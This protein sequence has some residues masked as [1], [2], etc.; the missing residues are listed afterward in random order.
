ML[1]PEL[2]EYAYRFE[3]QRYSI[4]NEYGDHEYTSHEVK[5]HV[6]PL[7]KRTDCGIWINEA[8]SSTYPRLPQDYS[9]QADRPARRF[10]NLQARKKFALPTITEAYESYLARKER[11]ISI[12]NARISGAIKHMDAAKAFMFKH[13]HNSNLGQ[14]HG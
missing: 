3:D 2:R 9:W 10:V 14:P 1:I 5:V 8:A 12:Y 6:Y 7:L 13:K 4:A 11:Q